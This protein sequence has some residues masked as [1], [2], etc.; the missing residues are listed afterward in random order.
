M[1]FIVFNSFPLDLTLIVFSW[2]ASFG[3]KCLLG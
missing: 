2:S 1:D 3:A